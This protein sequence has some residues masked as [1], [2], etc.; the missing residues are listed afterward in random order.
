MTLWCGQELPFDVSVELPHSRRSVSLIRVAL[1][2]A[3]HGDAEYLLLSL[4]IGVTETT[5]Y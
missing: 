1:S 2:F 5:A 4:M 3:A